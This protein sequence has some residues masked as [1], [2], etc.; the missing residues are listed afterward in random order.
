MFAEW[1]EAARNGATILIFYQLESCFGGEGN[2]VTGA[3]DGLGRVYCIYY[4][5][6][7]NSKIGAVTLS[8]VFFFF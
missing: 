7:V 3:C 5:I 4:M 2:T 8:N 1:L 6:W